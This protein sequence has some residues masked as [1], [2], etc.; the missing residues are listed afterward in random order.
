LWKLLTNHRTV[1]SPNHFSLT[2]VHLF[3]LSRNSAPDRGVFNTNILITMTNSSQTPSPPSLPSSVPPLN[4]AN[5]DALPLELKQRICS[6]LTPKELK[7]LRLTS[8]IFAKASERYFID[9]FILFNYP[10]SIAALGEIVDHEV[11]GKYLTTLVC[12]T[13]YLRV[14]KVVRRYRDRRPDF[15]PPSWDDYRPKT[16]LLD[17]NESYSSMTTRVMQR[18]NDEYQTACRDWEATR[19][20]NQALLNWYHTMVSDKGNDA[21]H[22]KI[23]ATLRKA[24]ERCPRLRNL[25]LSS[26]HTSTVKK[27]R[28][29][30]L[31]HEAFTVWGMPCWSDYLT[32]TWKSLSQLESLTLIS[33]GMLEKPANR[34]DLALPNLKHLRINRLSRNHH[35]ANELTNCALILRGAKSLET[36]SLLLPDHDI[37]RLVKSTRSDR[38][39]ECLLCFSSVDG[40][41]LV[42]FL[43]HHAV[44]M[45]RLALSD[46]DVDGDT[47][48]SWTSVFSG[49]AGRL[50]ALQRVQFENLGAP[51]VLIMTTGSAQ[52]AERFVAFGGPVPVLQYEDA[53]DINH[54]VGSSRGT[55][56]DEQKQSEP[57]SGLCQDYEQ[58]A[59]ELW[60]ETEETEHE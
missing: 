58:I 43:L 29:D 56:V 28:T 51:D 11:F 25:I 53:D 54:F 37:T 34:A 3:D 26:R 35:S 18:A 47:D 50:P 31:D 39:R 23:V 33:T 59:K 2:C 12:D 5:M 36:L 24:F 40:D 1:V 48:I 16:L 52:K 17:D 60:D 7:P 38:L 42:T 22:L 20:R 4:D 19:M 15:S 9:R 41:A 21:H 44:S 6:F 45:Q 49:I 30:M 13:S 55:H 27:R 57:P 8:I 10:D 46:G 14:Q 32:R